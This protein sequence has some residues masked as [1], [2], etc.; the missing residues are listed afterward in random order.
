MCMSHGD[1]IGLIEDAVMNVL[2][3]KCLRKVERKLKGTDKTLSNFP[4]EYYGF[5]DKCKKAVDR[6]ENDVVEEHMGHPSGT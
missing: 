3:E 6:A 5:C 1:L 4:K 2:C